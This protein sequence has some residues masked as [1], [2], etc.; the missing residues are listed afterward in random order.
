MKMNKYLM[1]EML[2]MG[3]WG[4]DVKNSIIK[5]NGS[6]QHLVHLPKKMREKY[7]TVW[8]MPMDH[9]IEMAADRGIYICQSQSLN[10]W[11]CDPNYKSITSM[12]F[13]SWKKGLKTGMYYLRT[14]AKAAPQQFTIEP[15]C[16]SC[17]A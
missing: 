5:N 1:E 7:L 8:E 6:I 11:M 14:R 17:S 13:N 2:N 10:L 12:H 9:L 4:E 16:E 15:E 3:L